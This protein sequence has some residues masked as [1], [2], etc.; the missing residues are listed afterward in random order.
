MLSFLFLLFSHFLG[1]VLAAIWRACGRHLDR[2]DLGSSFSYSDDFPSRV[3][4]L[5]LD[6][7]ISPKATAFPP[8]RVS[9]RRKMRHTTGR[10]YF[11]TE[12]LCLIGRLDR[13]ADSSAAV[14][15][16]S[17]RPGNR[18]NHGEMDHD[19]RSTHL[20]MD[21]DWTKQREGWT[22]SGEPPSFLSAPVSRPQGAP[23]ACA[24]AI[25]ASDRGNPNKV[26][27]HRMQ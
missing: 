18:H 23:E 6:S 15:R 22:D 24:S 10:E 27:N 3:T 2:E 5:R 9:V 16:S 17:R 11:T 1:P 14:H 19:D 13:Y 26:A 21:R 12:M 4:Q 8:S 25:D 7:A 20:S